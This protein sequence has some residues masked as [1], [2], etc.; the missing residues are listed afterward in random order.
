MRGSKNSHNM[1]EK[2]YR[3]RLNGQFST[4]LN[5]LPP[6]VVGA[7][8]EGYVRG[9]PGAE[10]KVSKAEVLILAKRHIETLERQ[11]SSL[12]GDHEVLIGDMQRL[13]E[14]WVGIGGQVL[15]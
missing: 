3:I 12:D 4:L 10:K 13:K 9:D 2:H 6:E 7:E 1:V 11:Y 14:A 15:S 5:A 8:I